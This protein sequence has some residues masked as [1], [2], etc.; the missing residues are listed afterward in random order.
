MRCKTKYHIECIK[1]N[2]ETLHELINKEEIEQ[3]VCDKC[4]EAD[5]TSNIT[6]NEQSITIDTNKVLQTQS[7]KNYGNP[8]IATESNSQQQLN[9]VSQV[10]ANKFQ[11]KSDQEFVTPMDLAEA[12]QVIGNR[13]RFRSPDQLLSRKQTKLSD[14]WLAKPISTQNRFEIF[15]QVDKNTEDTNQKT[16]DE[17]KPPPITIY[18]VQEIEPLHD[19]LREITKEYRLKIESDNRVKVQLLKAEHY[20]PV[21]QALDQKKT[22]YHTY[23]FK[24]D[25]SF[26]VV[27]KGWHPS[28]SNDIITKT[29][30]EAGHE[31]T[32]VW[33]IKHRATKDPLPMFFVDLKANDN[34]KDVYKIK[35]IG[36]HTVKF[37]PPRAKRVIPQ[38][39]K[40]QEYGH[41]KNFCRKSP[42]CVKCAGSHETS[43][44]PKQKRFDNV[45]CANCM[46]KHPA[47]YRGCMVHKQLQQKMYPT[48]R[49][50]RDEIQTRNTLNQQSQRTM[51][52]LPTNKHY[53]NTDNQHIQPTTYAQTNNYDH[54]FPK[55]PSQAGRSYAQMSNNTPQLE[56][57]NWQSNHPESIVNNQPT[58]DTSELKHLMRELIQ[59]NKENSRIMNTMLN[60]LTLLVN[61]INDSTLQI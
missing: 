17:T 6:S 61:K 20:D 21:I 24:R 7:D 30:L 16:S 46:G 55:L 44:C 9:F 41:T 12:F 10:G 4:K 45:T 40:C 33:N 13:K 52:F 43:N 18:M 57:T 60:L 51:T 23:K 53:K 39:S 28:S 26:R 8:L 34:N 5:I 25:R 29:L 48:L 42:R 27:L 14:Y 3:W 11:S 38:C 19:V 22:E 49:E 15:S 59:Q 54:T 58:N 56:N 36:N 35:T 32:N 31:V 1:V 2:I 37:E 50:K 47:N